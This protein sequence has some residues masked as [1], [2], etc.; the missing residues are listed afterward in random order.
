MPARPLAGARGA[1]RPPRHAQ[2]IVTRRATPSPITAAAGVRPVCGSAA[3]RRRRSGATIRS[4]RTPARMP[5]GGLWT[6]TRAPGS[7]AGTGDSN[8]DH[9]AALSTPHSQTRARGAPRRRQAAARNVVG[10]VSGGPK[11][12]RPRPSAPATVPGVAA[13][14][15]SADSSQSRPSVPAG[16]PMWS[17][18]R[19][20]AA[21]IRRHRSEN[22]GGAPALARRCVSTMHR[23]PLTTIEPRARAGPAC[24]RHAGIDW[25]WA[26]CC[27]RADGTGRCGG[28]LTCRALSRRP[29]PLAALTTMRAIGAFTP[30]SLFTRNAARSRT[31]SRA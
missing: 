5:R 30:T 12:A 19:A 23:P 31:Q 11:H 26:G 20:T 14:A 16:S 28:G 17:W 10:S 25:S 29:V 7:S 9:I 13:A 21:S 22:A 27:V 8:S 3:R 1:R 24:R 18:C 2:P 6:A 4:R 15:S